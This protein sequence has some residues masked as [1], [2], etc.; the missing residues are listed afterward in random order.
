MRKYLDENEVNTH[1][2]LGRTVEVFLGRINED[3]EIISYL[4]LSK[5]KEQKIEVTYIEH[6]DEGNLEFLDLYSFSY[7]DPDMDFET[8][9]FD[10]TEKAIKYIK[11]RFRL[12]K[13]N[14]VNAGIIQ[15]EY[16]ELLKAE[17]HS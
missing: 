1:L 12:G 11:E 2:N 4:T 6:Y 5:T 8:N 10:N 16:A 7:V 13:I 9:H 3:K 17:G 14:F 15:D